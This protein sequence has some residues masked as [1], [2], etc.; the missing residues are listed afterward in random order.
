MSARRLIQFP[1]RLESEEPR[2]R[3]GRISAEVKLATPGF[4]VAPALEARVEIDS[5]ALGCT[6]PL[7][8][9]LKSCIRNS[10]SHYNDILFDNMEKRSHTGS[11]F[12]FFR[13]T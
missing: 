9:K 5:G 7:A 6:L 4:L 1:T 2:L 13:K 8:R 12:W 10:G 3:A 11:R